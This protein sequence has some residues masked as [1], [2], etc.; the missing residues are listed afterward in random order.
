MAWGLAFW[1][2]GTSAWL[3]GFSATSFCLV[4][5]TCINLLAAVTLRWALARAL[6]S[7]L[8]CACLALIFLF[9]NLRVDPALPIWSV[10]L[11]VAGVFTFSRVGCTLI[12][13]ACFCVSAG[14]LATRGHG[15]KAIE[16]IALVLAPCLFNGLLL[17]A[18]PDLP[19]QALVAR[20]LLV[21][22]VNVVVVQL[23]ASLTGSSWV[24]RPPLL[25]LLLCASA[26]A[27]L[28]PTIADI[29]WRMSATSSAP[30]LLV[31]LVVFAAVSS[32]AALWA[33]TYLVTGFMMDALEGRA[34]GLDRALVHCRQ[35]AYRGAVYGGVFMTIL[36]L[37]FGAYHQ[38]AA[39]IVSFPYA[40]GAV[41]LGVL[42]P[43]IKTI[44]E[45]FDG[46]A[47]FITRLRRSLRDPLNYFRGAVLGVGVAL[48]LQVHL[49]IQDSWM[50]SAFGF[51]LGATVYAGAQYL[52]DWSRIG[53]RQRQYLQTGKIYLVQLLLGG[54]TGAALCWYC[55]SSQLQVILQKFYR[56]TTLSVDLPQAYI[57]Y[58]LFSKW[59]QLNLG[60]ETSGG[61]LL[62]NESLSG[63]IGWSLA[64]PL[65]SLNMVFLTALLKR[66]LR[67][68][69]EFATAEGFKR[70]IVQA[71]L[72]ER[73]GLWM[74]P[75]I[76]SFLRM[77]PDPQWYNQDGAVRT[78]IATGMSLALDQND[79]RT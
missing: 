62:F 58:P 63:V 54:V 78:V 45:S 48:A 38:F 31:F 79:F 35:G 44:V 2:A 21:L 51:L 59:G 6:P 64:A 10:P 65:F 72:V 68:V 75:I 27:A 47:P 17:L 60:L 28:S 37:L 42:F 46:S 53:I 36:Y 76:Y 67:P 5:A 19:N 4:V 24:L 18:S 57:V 32:Q 70:V 22:V 12:V 41:L 9:F 74:A 26:M 50:R 77:A 29:P 14:S 69:R 39:V 30:L 49:P 13:L 23:L 3:P 16:F 56:Y 43:L 7:L 34:P 40:S 52:W 1:L 33:Q 71:L 11:D 20:I 8:D 55:E 66:S 15:P 25:L 73:W 61:R